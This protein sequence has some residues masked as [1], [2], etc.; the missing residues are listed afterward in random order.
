[1]SEAALARAMEGDRDAAF[2]LLFK[3][4]L[5]ILTKA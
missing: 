4:T 5:Q 3:R 2:D 1:L